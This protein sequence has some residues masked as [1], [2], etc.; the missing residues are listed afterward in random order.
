M[1]EH[2]RIDLCEAQQVVDDASRLLEELD[3]TDSRLDE[4]TGPSRRSNHRLAQVSRDLLNLTSQL[5]LAASLVETEY[6]R[7]KGYQDPRGGM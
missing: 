2:F 5:R 1:S 7:L 3:G 6:W 4:G